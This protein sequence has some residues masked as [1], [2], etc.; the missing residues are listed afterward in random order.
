LSEA[1]EL[2]EHVCWTAV[3][4]FSLRIADASFLFDASG[5]VGEIL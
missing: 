1:W 4:A 3:A 2:K 5:A